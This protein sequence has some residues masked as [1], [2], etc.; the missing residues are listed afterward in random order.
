MS[1]PG[2]DSPLFEYTLDAE[3]RITGVSSEWVAFACENQAADLTLEHVVGQPLLEFI[4]DEETRLIYQVLLS[5]VRTTGHSLRVKFR[6]DSPA[7]RRFMELEIAPLDE[8]ALCL[9]GRL[10]KA[11]PR[12]AVPLLDTNQPRSDEILTICGWCKRVHLPEA[13]VEVEEAVERMQLFEQPRLPRLSHG[14]C[15]ACDLK[16]REEFGISD[17]A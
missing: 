14:I 6:C 13:W 7:L 5:K 2:S 9:G 3:D 8:G 10:L 1:V 15:P 16:M 17:T 4:S 11:E 12:E